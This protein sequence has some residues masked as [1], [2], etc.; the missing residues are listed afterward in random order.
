MVWTAGGP[1]KNINECLS[2][3]AM[4]SLFSSDFRLS[5]LEHLFCVVL[6]YNHH[7][8]ECVMFCFF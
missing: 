2:L 8:C 4:G 1:F 3:K 7:G 6:I 5:V